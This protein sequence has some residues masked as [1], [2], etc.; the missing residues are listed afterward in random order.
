[1]K[2]YSEYF[3]IDKS[4]NP[5]FTTDSRKD[6]DSWFK[7]FPHS[8]IVNLI[9]KM[10]KMLARGSAKDKRD[11]WIEGAYGTGK[12]RALWLL[13][14]LLE[15][16][17]EEVREYFKRYDILKNKTD[18]CEKLIGHKAKGPILTVFQ[19]NSGEITSLE[20]FISV[21]TDSVSQ[22]LRARNFREL[23]SKTMRGRVVAWLKEETH[24]MAMDALLQAPKWSCKGSFAGKSARDILN[25]LSNP[26]GGNSNLLEDVVNLFDEE[27]IE[28]SARATMADLKEWLS[29][30]IKANNLHGIVFFWDEF[31]TFFKSNRVPLD[32]FQELAEFSAL[33][34]FNL[35]FAT[36]MRHYVAPREELTKAPGSFMAVYD[37]FTHVEI[38][39]PNDVAFD[40]IGDAIKI[41]E[42]SRTDYEDSLQE[43]VRRTSYARTRVSEAIGLKERNEV[44][45]KFLPIHPMSALLLKY[46]AES[47][48]SNQRSM[49]NFIKNDDGDNLRAF[50]WFIKNKEPGKLDI[51][52]IDYLWDFFYE[53]GTDKGN[54]GSVGKHNLDPEVSRIL[55]AYHLNKEKLENDEDRRLY[56]IVLMMQAI[57]QRLDFEEKLLSP[58]ESNITLAVSGDEALSEK[59]VNTIKHKLVEKLHVLYEDRDGKEV[60]YLTPSMNSGDS[61]AIEREKDLL[62][63]NVKTSNLLDVKNEKIIDIFKFSQAV[64]ERFKFFTA[65][66]ENFKRVRDLDARSGSSYKFPCILTFARDEGE[67][68]KVRSL[69]KETLEDSE[70]SWGNLIIVDATDTLFDSNGSE[71]LEQYLSYRAQGNVMEARDPG[72]AHS[73]F[74]AAEGMIV[75]WHNEIVENGTFVLYSL[76]KDPAHSREKV[77]SQT[78]LQLKDSLQ[79][80]VKKIFPLSIDNLVSSD[81]LFEEKNYELGAKLGFIRGVDERLLEEKKPREGVFSNALIEQLLGKIIANSHNDYK[82]WEDPAC[83]DMPVSKLKKELDKYIRRKIKSDARV[84]F[85]DIYKFLADQG[86]L[87]CGIYA[88]LLGFLL[89]D[90]VKP[91]SEYRYSLGKTGDSG[92][93]AKYGVFAGFINDVFKN[94]SSGM[95]IKMVP[96]IEL[97]SQNQL[98]FVKFISEVFQV[99]NTL[100]VEQ[101]ALKLRDKIKEL[102]FPLWTLKYAQDAPAWDV[103]VDQLSKIVSSSVDTGVASLTEK[104]GKI[105]AADM[106]KNP[107]LINQA[108]AFFTL[109]NAKQGVTNF[110]TS[111]ENGEIPLLAKKLGVIDYLGDV[112]RKI[113]CDG[114]WVWVRETAEDAL[115]EL[116]T[117][118]K[119]MSLSESGKSKRATS[120]DEC[121]ESWKEICKNIHIPASILREAYPELGEFCDILLTIVKENRFPNVNNNLSRFL[122][123]LETKSESVANFSDNAKD[124]V[125]RKRY[126]DLL[127]GVEDLA[128]KIYY[129]E[130][131]K[132]AFSMDETRYRGLLKTAAN[133][134]RE[135]QIVARLKREWKKRTGSESPKSWSDEHSTPIAIMVPDGGK[136]KE[137]AKN[138]FETLCGQRTD[139]EAIEAAQAYFPNATF[140]DSLGDQEK[141]DAAFLEKIVRNYSTILDDVNAVRKSLKENRGD[142]P[143]AW[144]GNPDVDR[145]VKELATEEYCKE[146]GASKRLLQEIDAKSAQEAKELLKR[147]V[148]KYVDVGMALM[149]KEEM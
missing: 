95:E 35:I 71:R 110:L 63:Q 62:R 16:E 144:Y 46:I 115:R 137:E 147:L 82:Y 149:M 107:E 120:F 57:S 125:F 119:I 145:F 96:Y 86:F 76:Y 113:A 9:E 94:A 23:G 69:I 103:Y 60:R 104:F 34:R 26:E 127:N 99:E 6:K 78:V 139:R 7:T 67:R 92:G 52:T 101:T 126:A 141:I 18:L 49:F 39:M 3:E 13:Q 70:H 47:F 93:E 79:R 132:D 142:H 32:K 131:L 68:S 30:V 123:V 108:K 15:V 136:E 138:L 27:G 116:L 38:K 102:S 77:Y 118:Y 20:R 128:E 81:K 109:D 80:F 121:V 90:Y 4:Y 5:V 117:E 61:A 2:K 124:I 146:G 72:A 43:M 59:G 129:D 133:R 42:A 134:V 44:F 41:K 54:E 10:E 50:Q 12:S 85:L 112:R 111:F 8:T 31:S 135:G 25:A 140:V 148:L 56:K 105:V 1:M 114:T 100:A 33:E 74:D 143:D 66:G 11:I 37:R 64:K 98:K 24:L 21:V 51:L 40:L 89:R 55:D 88:Y 36:H 45:K 83:D 87:P 22:A 91:D 97:M 122:N 19:P 28:K 73:K 130:T 53:H 29:E 58:T 65:T 84:S 48:A 106:E 17:P 75:A 14:R